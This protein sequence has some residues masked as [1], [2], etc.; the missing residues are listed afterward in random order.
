MMDYPLTVCG[1]LD[2][3][4]KRKKSLLNYVKKILFL[5]K[6]KQLLWLLTCIRVTL[7]YYITFVVWDLE[8]RRY[9]SLQNLY[10]KKP[11]YDWTIRS[12]TCVLRET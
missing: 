6:Y 12:T 8:E 10:I 2:L 7:V 5:K 9:L 11:L 3:S 4:H 1:T